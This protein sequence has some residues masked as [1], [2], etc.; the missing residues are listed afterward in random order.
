MVSEINR[1][2]GAPLQPKVVA[3]VNTGVHKRVENTC[4]LDSFRI[5]F[6][7]STLHSIGS[8]PSRDIRKFGYL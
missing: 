8:W 1:R 6:K 2:T 3:K 5:M 7:E 4:G